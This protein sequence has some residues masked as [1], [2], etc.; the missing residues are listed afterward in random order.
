MHIGTPGNVDKG[1][2]IK[3]KTPLLVE[4][5]DKIRYLCPNCVRE[6]KE[7]LVAAKGNPNMKRI[8]L[9]PGQWRQRLPDGR[10]VPLRNIKRRK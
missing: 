1:F 10:A 4:L 7:K 6:I 2:C 8:V 5:P 9:Q 3:C